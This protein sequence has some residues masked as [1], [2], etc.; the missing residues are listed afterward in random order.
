M[1]IALQ[2]LLIGAGLG[3]LLF[4]FEYFSAHKSAN[5]RG[6]HQAK[7]PE[8]NQDERARIASMLRFC[9]FIPPGVAIIAWLVWG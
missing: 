1:H 6:K 4:L 2:G 9:F 7:K 3:L 5:A 8:L